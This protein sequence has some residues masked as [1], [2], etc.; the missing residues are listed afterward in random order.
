M[1]DIVQDSGR[2]VRVDGH[3]FWAVQCTKHFHEGNEPSA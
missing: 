1:G 3:A 2:T